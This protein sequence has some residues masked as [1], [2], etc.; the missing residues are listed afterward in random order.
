M[1]EPEPLHLDPALPD[2]LRDALSCYREVAPRPEAASRLLARVERELPAPTRPRWR[3]YLGLAVLTAL[4]GPSALFLR[5][6]TPVASPV[7]AASVPAA[8][9]E[10][11]THKP[12]VEHAAEPATEPAAEPIAEP[13][14]RRAPA[15]A[16]K[17][18]Q[19]PDMA[20]ELALLARAKRSLAL[21]AARA[22][23]LSEQHAALYPHG[24]LAEEREV[25]AIEALVR[26]GQ[27]EQARLRAT[28]FRAAHARST[29][30]ARIEVILAAR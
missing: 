15:P 29:H 23:A 3:V 26:S 8:V 14:V 4:L 6:H 30:L 16:P 11:P 9:L 18:S 1:N 17:R 7:P 12:L 28:R 25:I 5:E 24:L 21:D 20:G 22:L 27:L 19:P 13:V 2:E 10:Q